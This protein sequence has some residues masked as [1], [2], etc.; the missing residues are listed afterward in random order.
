[1]DKRIE[2]IK[3]RMEL[4]LSCS[5]HNIDHVMR[6][7]NL[8]KLIAETEEN[9]DMNI[10][11]S[12]ALLHDIARTIES[13]DTS[14]NLDHAVLGSMMAVGILEELE[15]SQEEIKQIQ[16]CILTHRYRTGNIPQTIEAKILFDSDKLDVIGSVGISRTFM[17]AG[18]FGQRITA[19]LSD[20]YTKTNTVQNGRLKDVS[21]HSPMMEY[22]YKFKNIPSK[23]F[24]QKGK[25]I[26]NHRLEY[27]K[28][29]FE[30]LDKEIKGEL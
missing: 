2:M 21:K 18:Q 1:M 16:H 20:E 23:L 26:G 4:E 5:A 14:G 27:M 13:D 10:L 11:E 17:L 30:R 6:V 7:Y 29:F 28:E 25:D 22:E 12:A 9:V 8:C 24:T 3:V 15:Y 19:N